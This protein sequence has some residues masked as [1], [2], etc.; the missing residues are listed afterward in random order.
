MRT[1][2]I[3]YNAGN[4]RS[5]LFAM[6]R[7]GIE[8]DLTADPERIKT[9][10]RVIFP[11]VGEASSTMQFLREQGLDRLIRNL[12]QPT[13]GI[14]LGMQLLCDHSEEGD[15]ACL[16][17][18]PQQVRRFQPAAGEKIPHMGWNTL[19]PTP[20]SWL[21]ASLAGEHVYYV[22]SFYAEAGPST[23]ALTDYVLPFSAAL[24]KDNFYAVQFHPEKSGA[25]GEQILRAFFA[26]P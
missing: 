3:D 23:S 5:V 13:L 20:D 6:E 7:L 1:A 25:V 19:R 17:I 15:T 18:I 10:D 22:H 8:A 16:G 4:I 26:A 12:R 9:A 2:I 24:R 14:C 21:P 11:G